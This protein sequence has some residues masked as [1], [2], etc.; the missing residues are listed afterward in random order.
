[1]KKYSYRTKEIGT[2]VFGIDDNILSNIAIFQNANEVEGDVSKNIPESL[3][4]LTKKIDAYLSGDSS[5]V[6]ENIFK[7]EGT[8]FQK[9]VWKEISKIPYG[10]TKSYQ[11]IA[12]AINRPRAV[13]AVGTAC[14]ANKLALI[15][16]CHRVVSS[17]GKNSG[18]RWGSEIKEKLLELET[19]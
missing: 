10:K 2:I 14:G 19:R 17:T 12:K 11:D 5:L 4:P 16:P 15:I 3:K 18:Y 8:D 9:S 6:Y 1:M 13:R 7:Q